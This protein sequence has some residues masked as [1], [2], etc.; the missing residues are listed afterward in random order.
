[1]KYDERRDHRAQTGVGDVV[2]HRERDN[3]RDAG[4]G[5]ERHER[6]DR[7]AP[8]AESPEG[9]DERAQHRRARNVARSRVEDQRDSDG[10]D[11]VPDNARHVTEPVVHPPDR[12]EP[13]YADGRCDLAPLRLVRERVD[14][15]DLIEAGRPGE[16]RRGLDRRRLPLA[17]REQDECREGAEPGV[18]QPVRPRDHPEPR[19]H[20]VHRLADRAQRRA[21]RRKEQ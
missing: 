8:A 20:G 11:R 19:L 14:C 6:L 17:E 7:P 16:P 21:K 2:L 18:A 3:R 12:V 4:G 1:M 10:E 5:E 9:A 15:G 13:L